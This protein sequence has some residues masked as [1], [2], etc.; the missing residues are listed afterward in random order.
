MLDLIRALNEVSDRGRIEAPEFAPERPGEVRRSG[1][2]VRRAERDL[3]FKAEVELADGLRR[4][5]ANL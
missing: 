5:L 2:D 1:L 3:G 4:I